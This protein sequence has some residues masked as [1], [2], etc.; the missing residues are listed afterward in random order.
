LPKK[1][2]KERIDL[3]VVNDVGEK[4]VE[5][6]NFGGLSKLLELQ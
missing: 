1:T 4:D 3:V 5:I 6:E 2:R